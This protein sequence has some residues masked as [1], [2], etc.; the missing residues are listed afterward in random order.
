[1]TEMKFYG[2]S[3]CNTCRRALR[4]LA[5]RGIEP[6][7]IAIREHPPTKLELERALA[8]AGGEL[9]RLFNVSGG[10]YKTLNMKEKLTT[11][12]TE[13]ALELLGKNGS[14]VKRPFV[15]RGKEAWVGYYEDVWKERFA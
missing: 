6:E 7:V 4:F 15:V 11:L 9:K 14:L 2:Y 10:D 5:A 8:S 3:G 13:A 1:M 12:S